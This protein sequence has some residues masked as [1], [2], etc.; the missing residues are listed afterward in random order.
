M[1][2]DR[3]QIDSLLFS[4]WGK[5]PKRLGYGLLAITIAI[6]QIFAVVP[7]RAATPAALVQQGKIAYERGDFPAALTN[8]E[9]A[10]TSYRDGRDAIGVAGSQVNQAQALMGMGLYRRACKLL[11]GTVRVDESTCETT[12][13]DRFG[14]RQTTLPPQLQV[15]AVGILGDVLRLLGNLDAAQ[16]ALATAGA[17]AKPLQLEDRAPILVSLADTL[18]DLGNRDR[19][20]TARMEIP[21]GALS[22]PTQPLSNLLEAGEYY[23]RAIACYRQADTLT[24][25]IDSLGLQVEISHWLKE[26]DLPESNRNWQQEFN[27]SVLIDRIK[28][29]LNA[30]PFTT[31]GLERRINFARS[32][33]IAERP[34]RTA[35]RELLTTVITQARSLNRKSVL[36]NATGTLG[37]L[38]EGDRQWSQAAE[39]THQA[40]S[41]TANIGDDNR[42]QWEWQL[43]R[44]FQHQSQ[45]ELGQAKAAYD[46][47]V[48]ALEQTRRNIRVINPDA[49]FSLRDRIEPLYRELVDLSLRLPQPNLPEIIDRVDAL[50]LAELENF[51]QCQL[52]EYRSVSEFAQDA[53]AVVFYPIILADRLE[54]ILQL[55]EHKFQRLTIPV[56]RSQLEATISSFQQ[57]LTQP[58]YG[59]NEAAAAQLYDW[60]IRSAQRY[61]SPQTKNLVFVMDG[62]LQNIPVAAL[63]DRSRREYLIDRYPV[64]LTPSLKIL[65]AKQSMADRTNI[66]IGGLTTT[67]SVADRANIPSA[68]IS[69]SQR[70]DVD[71]PLIY[72]ASEIQA[73]KSLFPQAT[74]LVGK[75]F[76]QEKIRQQLASG[77]YGTLHLATHGRFSSDP[78]QNF[79]VTDGG[80]SID[81]GQLRAILRQNR[82]RS[83][84]LL[85][86]SACETA[87]GDRR[88]ALG[89]AGTAIRSGAGSTL[90]SLWSVDDRATAKLMQQFYGTLTGRDRVSKAEALRAAQ[91]AIRQE[92]EHPYYWAPF[93]LLGNWL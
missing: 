78:R 3:N 68:T 11:S 84:D 79:I 16:V 48:A 74:E 37:W 85:V 24:A 14:I 52:G 34:D 36:A 91:I 8:W 26:R 72:A 31:E 65:G 7:A 73:I 82:S 19:Q 17:I 33:A 47:A 39:F 92:Y 80:R 38:Y 62:V 28:A 27:Q 6:A 70:R 75:N 42:Y 23:Q 76:T 22:C 63:Y 2:R 59:W 93:V 41:L 83:I 30:E 32:L 67:Q 64:A 66:L 9:R 10:E 88:A 69:K 61:L 45:P 5:L 53:G 20:R 44:I 1:T 71:T 21:A 18:R 55:A 49:Q 90:A 4:C 86:L 89:L 54:I 58:Q 87:T 29:G 77:D 15:L 12:I 57:S 81:F 46:R 50:K 51:L 60:L 25:Q 40:L 56:S 35:A 13:P 43:G